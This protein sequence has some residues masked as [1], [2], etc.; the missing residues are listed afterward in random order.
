M[1]VSALYS[2]VTYSLALVTDYMQQRVQQEF[3][4][5]VYP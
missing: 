5:K 3:L 2:S 1:Y 4:T